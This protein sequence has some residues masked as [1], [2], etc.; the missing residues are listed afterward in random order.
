[1]DYQYNNANLKTVRRTLRKNQTDAERKL[2]QHLRNK[3][4][5]DLKFFR[6]YSVGRYILDFY[7][8]KIRLA[9][10][11]DGGQHDEPENQI[12]DNIRTASLNQQGIKVIRFW[13]NDV[14]GNMEGVIEK[15]LE[16]A[17]K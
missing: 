15:I 1:M 11:L 6:Q 16:V 3:Q 5:D 4:I 7:C 14:M 12:Q 2:W 9:I 17:K 10:E 13:N 8:P